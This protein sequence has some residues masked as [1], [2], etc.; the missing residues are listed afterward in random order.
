MGYGADRKTR[1]EFTNYD[2]R[3]TQPTIYKILLSPQ[4]RETKVKKESI[5]RILM[6]RERFEYLWEGIDES[7]YFLNN[8]GNKEDK[9]DRIS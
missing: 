5:L 2:P 1:L 7:L 3:L 9:T 4:V 6:T 8:I